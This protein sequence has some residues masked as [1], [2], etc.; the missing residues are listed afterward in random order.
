MHALR[1]AMHATGNGKRG[2]KPLA[3]KV[4]HGGGDYV[5]SIPFL[6]V[7]QGGGIRSHL[8]LLYRS[9][10]PL[11]HGHVSLMRFLIPYPW[12]FDAH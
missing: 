3:N 11:T 10:Y 6:A 4:G 1:K 7:P 9:V 8:A 2:G 12:C 5:S